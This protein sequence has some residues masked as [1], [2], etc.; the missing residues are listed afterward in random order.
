MNLVQSQ[1][2]TFMPV[3]LAQAAA[4]CRVDGTDHDVYLTAL[5]KAAT[6]HIQNTCNRQIAPATY[7]YKF[8]EFGEAECIELPR[9]PLQSVT[10]IAYLDTDGN[11][12]T[13]SS[14]NYSVDTGSEPGR[15]ILNETAS[16]PTTQTV[17]NAITITYRAGY[18]STIQPDQSA[19]IVTI[20]GLTYPTDAIVQIYSEGGA[21]PA[22]LEEAKD[23]YLLGMTSGNVGQLSLTSG[24]AAVAFTTNGTGTMYVDETPEAL[25]AAIKLLIGHLFE[26]REQVVIGQGFSPIDIPKGMEYLILDYIVRNY[27]GWQT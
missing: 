10:S 24:G 14:A 3:T 18:G 22:E 8:D 21:L 5:S 2:P 17:P 1:A 6:T 11:S 23:Y 15:V 4:H 25:R 19:N 16:W 9:P 13:Y 27:A 20:T 26:N 7:V 12:Q